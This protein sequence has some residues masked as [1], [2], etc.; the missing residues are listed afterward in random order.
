MFVYLALH[1]EHDVAA[2]REKTFH[3]KL[4]QCEA[5]AIF[6]YTCMVKINDSSIFKDPRGSQDGPLES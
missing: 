4:G 2:V 3:M 1:S 6:V 5:F